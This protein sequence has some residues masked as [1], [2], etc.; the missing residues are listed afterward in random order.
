MRRIIFIVLVLLAG[1]LLG[2]LFEKGASLLPNSLADVLTHA[3][4]V[5]IHPLAIH[6]NICGL[7]GLIIGF[8]VINKF[9]RK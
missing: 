3:Y 5:G 4:A 6:I 1:G 8:I 9:I 7:L 2:W